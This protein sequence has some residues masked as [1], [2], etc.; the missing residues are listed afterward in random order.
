MEPAPAEARPT[1]PVRETDGRQRFNGV[2]G[3]IQA[4]GILAGDPGPA[5][6]NWIDGG[7]RFSYTATNPST[8]VEE[9]RVFDPATLNDDVIFT[10]SSLRLEDG[11]PLTYN[12]FQWASDSRHVLFQTDFRPIYRRSGIS[13]Y[14]LYDLESGDL[15]LVADDVRSAELSPD[16]G[17]VGYERGGDLYAFDLSSAQ[18]VRLTTD[19]SE[20]IFNGVFDWVY[21]EEFGI[22][23][24][25]EWSPDGNHIAF[26]QT[27]EREV[28]SIAITDWSGLNPEFVEIRIP[29][30][31]EANPSVRIGVADV[32]DG[33]VVWLDTG[34]S[35]EHYI[36]RIYW[37]SRPNTLAMVTLNRPQNHV[38]L[39]FFD[40]TTGERELVFERRSDTWIDVYDFFAGILHFFFFPEGLEEFHWISDQDG[41]QHLYRYD[42]EGNLLNQVTSGPWN[43]IRVEA[44]DLESRTIFYTSAEESPLER[45]LYAVGFDGSGKRR[46]TEGRGNHGLDVGPNGKYYIDR[47]SNTETPLQVELRST[48]DGR[49]TLLEDNAP[50]ARW[51][52]SNAYSPAELFTFETS[53]GV[54]LDG[55]MV[56]PPGF[57]PSRAYPVVVSIYGGPGSQQVYDQFASDFFDQ[58]LAQQGY[59]VVGLNNRGSGNY[60]RD[61]MK[62]VYRRIGHWEAN[63]FA[64]VGRY[65]ASQP[66]V[67]G[68]RMAI[69][70][71]SYGGY[72]TIF[73]MLAHPNVFQVGIA[74]SPGTDWRIY[75]TIYTERYMG[76]LSDNVDGY[77]AS[78]V[79]SMVN[80]LEGHLLLVHSGMDENVQPRHTMQLIT[81]LTDAGK[82]AELRFYPR[83]AHGAAYSLESFVVMQRVYEQTLCRFLKADCS[84]VFLNR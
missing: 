73:T 75:D 4:A 33:G 32:R 71:T 49:L 43:V 78:S 64:E 8:R 48:V 56:R 44:V 19:G 17:M 39:F 50:T 79:M 58:Y 38:R 70:G 76:L 46:L 35:E 82:D 26:W 30:V 60:G 36:P 27:D 57:D 53:D 83:G 10:A 80:N 1:A 13:D 51:T 9:V 7:D 2:F 29:K 63:D 5:S 15:N 55:S 67:D 3:A 74:N 14:Y 81:A 77:E 31:G 11:S 54:T 42:Y 18:T 16:G 66:W 20:L 37:T 6:V 52:E 72:T 12:S 21:E 45:Q 23:E 47:W 61:F 84:N 41:H 28:G 68:D 59:I 24:A 40:V 34:L 22:A 62:M 65:L 69:M 25:W